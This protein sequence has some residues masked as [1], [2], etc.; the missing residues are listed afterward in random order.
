MT[1]KLFQ[2]T[3]TVT[4]NANLLPIEQ[5]FGLFTK[6]EDAERR[7]EILYESVNMKVALKGMCFNFFVKQV[8]VDPEMPNPDGV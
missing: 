7:A 5:N 8:D 1:N 3:R 4:V 2:V 6:R